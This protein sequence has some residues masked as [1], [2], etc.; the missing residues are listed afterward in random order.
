M[1]L[2]ESALVILVPEAE[3][4]VRSFRDR[5]DPS[6]AAGVPAHITLLYPFR[7]PEEIDADVI[8][9]LRQCFASFAPFEFDLAAVR[10]F[11]GVLYL[12]PEPGEP[13][14]ELTMAIWSRYPETPPYRRKYA[15]IVPHLCV[16]QIPDE[17]RLDCVAKALSRAFHEQA[18]VHATAAEVALME[19]GSGR[20]RVR[21]MIRLGRDLAAAGTQ[22]VS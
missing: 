1:E 14:R 12:A 21:T 6:A 8:A 4:L 10:R 19:S 5:H 15:D 20:W 17:Q 18:R 3:A 9:S 2:A 7:A 11:P 16:A 22:P 13:F